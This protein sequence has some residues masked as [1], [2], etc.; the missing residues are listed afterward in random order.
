MAYTRLLPPESVTP[1]CICGLGDFGPQGLDGGL[2]LFGQ[3]HV[4]FFTPGSDGEFVW[5]LLKLS[6]PPCH[7]HGTWCQTTSPDAYQTLHPRLIETQL[8]TCQPENGL[9]GHTG[10]SVGKKKTCL[11]DVAYSASE[12]SHVVS[13][14]VCRKSFPWCARAYQVTR[15]RSRNSERSKSIN[16]S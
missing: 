8:A 4:G 6:R 12:S 1:D 14:F 2:V 11:V 13:W 7:T 9:S 3:T 10:C 5:G 16:L 15:G